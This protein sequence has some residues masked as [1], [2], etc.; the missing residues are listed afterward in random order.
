[1]RRID[2]PGEVNSLVTRRQYQQTRGTVARAAFVLALALGAGTVSQ[3]LAPRWRQ[4]DNGLELARF[5]VT[6]EAPAGDSLITVVHIDPDLW[7]VRLLSISEFQTARSM[8]A[9]QWCERH[10]LTAAINAGMFA[11]DNMARHVGYMKSGN[12][13][14]NGYANQYLSAAAFHPVREGLPPFRIFDL[15]VDSLGSIKTQYQSLVQNLRLI[16]RPGE[17]RWSQQDKKW[18]EAALGEDKQ[19]RVLFIFCRSPYSMYDFNHL[20]LSL[21]IDLVCAQHLEGGPEA[22]LVINH[23]SLHL[24]MFGSYETNFNPNDRS[25]NAWPIPNVI[26][27][28]ARRPAPPSADE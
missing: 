26:G 7:D 28:T 21:P 20:L 1:M 17:N 10:D 23:D 13:V 25:R 22:Q 24:E 6:S 8:T 12:H 14:N 19:G 16:K 18:S 27:I 4:L 3:T 15:D 9:R 11:A 5:K 2:K